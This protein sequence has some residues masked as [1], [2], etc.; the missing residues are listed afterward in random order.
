MDKSMENE[1]ETHA[2]YRF[3]EVISVAKSKLKSR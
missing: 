1:M 2:L 3:V